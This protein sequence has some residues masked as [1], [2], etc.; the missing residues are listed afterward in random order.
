[1]MQIAEVVVGEG[2]GA[3]SCLCILQ[4]GTCLPVTQHSTANELLLEPEL[5][6]GKFHSSVLVG[7]D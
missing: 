6:Q 3:C 1:M 5:R 7:L 2:A 4:T